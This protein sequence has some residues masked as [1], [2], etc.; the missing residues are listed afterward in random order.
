MS[1]NALTRLFNTTFSKGNKPVWE[2]AK[3]FLRDHL[4]LWGNVDVD[5]ET[6]QELKAIFD[7]NYGSSDAKEESV[8]NLYSS[9]SLFIQ[10][11][12]G[13]LNNTAG[14][15]WSYTSHSGSPVGVFAK[16]Q[17]AEKFISVRDNTD[18]APMIS[19]LAGYKR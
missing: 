17:G 13:Y 6:E 12:I 8:V 5:K 19:E 10:R 14:Y 9:N 4:G 15:Y 2:D 1:A 7:R 16:G 18:I 3:G 11:A